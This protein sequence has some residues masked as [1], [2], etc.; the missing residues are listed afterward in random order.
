MGTRGD[1]G[2]RRWTG[3]IL[4]WSSFQP[5]GSDDAQSVEVLWRKP[6]VQV[7]VRRPLHILRKRRVHIN[8]N[9]NYQFI[10]RKVEIQIYNL[11]STTNIDPPEIKKKKKK[12]KKVLCVHSTT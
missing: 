5:D 2:K 7:S 12:K 8:P 3:S 9:I 4:Q 1:K 10:W 6:P 11:L